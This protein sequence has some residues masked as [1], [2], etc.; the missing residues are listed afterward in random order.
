M[1]KRNKQ[2][3]P[4]EVLYNKYFNCVP[5]S[6]MKLSEISNKIKAIIGAQLAPD[7][8]PAADI[9][10]ALD[11]KMKELVVEYREDAPAAT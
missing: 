11:A 10:A 4:V 3:S 5:V 8:A 7:N 2:P 6:V 1:R 9:A